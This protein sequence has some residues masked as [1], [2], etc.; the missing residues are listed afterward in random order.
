MCIHPWMG[1]R[2]KY[3]CSIMPCV[4]KTCG[5]VW[6]ECANLCFGNPASFEWEVKV[7]RCLLYVVMFVVIQSKNEYCFR[8][9]KRSQK[10]YL[11]LHNKMS[12]LSQYRLLNG[13]QVVQRLH[14]NGYYSLILWSLY[15]SM[16]SLILE[17]EPDILITKFIM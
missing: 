2:V 13:W 5:K 10:W 8:N 7:Q 9:K 15:F 3:N 11:L 12:Q 1:S 16:P 4:G 17:T 14:M 6:C